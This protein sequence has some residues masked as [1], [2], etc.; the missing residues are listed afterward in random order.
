MP[1][2]DA[3]RS[4]GA[5]L[6]YDMRHQPTSARCPEPDVR[7][8]AHLGPSGRPHRRMLSALQLNLDK[9]P[10]SRGRTQ[11]RGAR[12][13][14]QGC[15]SGFPATRRP[16]STTGL[17]DPSV[18]SRQRIR[19]SAESGL[20]SRSRAPPATAR[21]RSASSVSA[22]IM[23]IGRAGRSC[24]TRSCS[25]RPLIPGMFTSVRRQE[26]SP[27]ASEARN[28]SPELNASAS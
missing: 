11:R 26:T 25:S 14:R 13:D 4:F 7:L 27:P 8:R 9:Y 3:M 15:P 16:G 20:R 19:S 23:M 12:R 22:V 10:G 6:V 2:S 18:S 5:G 21:R 17:Q 1:W 24:R 28:A